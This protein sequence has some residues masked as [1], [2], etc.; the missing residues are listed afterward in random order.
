MAAAVKLSDDMI[1]R[2]KHLAELKQ[3]SAHWVM[4]EAVRQYVS[5]EEAR[6]SFKQ[7]ALASWEHYQQT[8]LH[9]TG[10]ELYKWLRTWGTEANQGVP[11]CHK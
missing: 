2:V 9:I 10:Q 7:E 1:K 6:E 11:K 4:C 8:G 3:R 5:H